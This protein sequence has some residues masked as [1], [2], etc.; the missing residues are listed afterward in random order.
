L[1]SVR[2]LLSN[3]QRDIEDPVFLHV[4]GKRP[5]F[6][7]PVVLSLG[8]LEVKGY[9]YYDPAR[10]QQGREG[11]YT[12]LHDTLEKLRGTRVPGW[13]RAEEVFKEKAGAMAN[14]ISWRVDGDGF[15]VEARKNAVSQYVN[16]LG[17][18]I[19]LYKGDVDWQSCLA[20]YREKDIVEKAFRTLK[21]DVEA[22]PLNTHKEETT[23]GLLFACYLG[24]LLK[25]RLLKRMREAGLLE[26]YTVDSLLL[27]LEKIK[28]IKL[29]DGTMMTNELTRRHK[30]ILNRLQLCA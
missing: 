9:C 12:R 28:K 10:D 14:Y 27:E 5:L 16:R 6:V 3:V 13:R 29:E 26:E 8:T 4:Y 11:F 7:K 30:G 18:Y 21:T 15:R 22:S 20:V 17:K 2:E 1:K 19:L 25:M 24:L 23:R